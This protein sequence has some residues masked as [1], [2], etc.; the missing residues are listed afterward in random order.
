[1]NIKVVSLDGGQPTL[2]QY[3]IRWLFRF[4][5]FAITSNLCALICVAVSERKQRV[6]DMVAGTTL[7]KTIP[8]TAFQQTIYVPTQQVDYTV[9][10]PEVANLGDKDMQLIKEVIININRTGNSMLAFQA[11]EKI[12]ETLQI[13]TSLEPIQFL[14]ILLTDYNHITSR[15]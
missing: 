2:G 10:F 14:Q 13:Q 9:S 6:G 3:I 7:I 8:R 4:I 5:D 15:E 12:K 1:M 11:A